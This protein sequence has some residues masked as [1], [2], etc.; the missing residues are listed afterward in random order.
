MKL[1]RLAII[2]LP[3]SVKSVSEEFPIGVG[4]VQIELM[5]EKERKNEISVVILAVKDVTDK[6]T[7]NSRGYLDLDNDVLDACHRAI[8]IL[9]NLLSVSRHCRR[10]LSSPTPTCALLPD[11]PDEESFLQQSLG[12]QAN[13]PVRFDF[14]A[15]CKTD[16]FDINVLADR[17]DGVALLAEALSHTHATGQFH[18]LM[19][20][21]ERAFGHHG[22]GL[23]KPTLH[24]LQG[25]KLNFTKKELLHWFKDIRNPTTHAFSG[26]FLLEKD[27]SPVIGRMKMAAY[28]VL[29]NKSNWGDSSWDRRATWRPSSGPNDNEMGFFITKG[30]ESTMRA[31]LLDPLGVYPLDL[32]GVLTRVPDDW[33]TRF[34][35]EGSAE[36]P[37]SGQFSGGATLTVL[38]E[39]ADQ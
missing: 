22:Q 29:I 11:G 18:D 37:T 32:Q 27:V 30:R 12:I 31:Q 25:A 4:D 15:G 5:L 33:Y 3:K 2:N 1:I 28:D 38:P 35:N 26:D 6:V 7:K 16:E 36:D 13:S 17:H 14:T 19:R 20:F 23:Y 39:G 21:F 34:S 8:E 9:A 10:N 24:F